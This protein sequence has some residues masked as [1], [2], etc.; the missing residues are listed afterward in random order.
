MSSASDR[1]RLA[2]VLSRHRPDLRPY[3]DYYK[4]FH[5]NPEL[6]RQESRTA[7]IVVDFL[8]EVGSYR[9]VDRIGGHG[10]VGVLE[11]GP[12]PKILLR[13]DM[14]ALPVPERTGLEYAS[15]KR[16]VDPE[17][18]DVPIMHACKPFPTGS[19]NSAP[20]FCFLRYATDRH[21]NITSGGHDM[22]V[23]PLMA[24][25]KLM[26]DARKDWSGTLIVLFQ[27]NEELAGGA[28]A[29]VDDGLYGDKHQIP[30][31]DVVLGQHVLVIK[32]GTVAVA[33]GPVLT[34]VDSL[35]IRVWGRGGHGSSAHKCID[36]VLTAAHVVIRLQ[37]VVR[38]EAAPSELAVLSVGSIQAGD[39]SNVI[40][41][42]ADI[43]LTIR[44]FLPQ[45]HERILS[46]VHRIVRAECDACE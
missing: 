7:R 40:P 3:E 43:K 32:A 23:A 45:I 39:A 29:M 27:P 42:Y 9:V 33:P 20:S 12:G 46:A 37:S 38:A 25:A 13:A 19:K 36:P 22:H 6:S 14:D 30:I 15:C 21:L 11:N 35:S 24:V 17:G 41:D 16:G 28:Q 5:R 34:A 2:T 31:P 8:R 44:T 4:D 18:R 26:R 1:E 10:V